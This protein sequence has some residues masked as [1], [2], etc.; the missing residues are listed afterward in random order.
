MENFGPVLDDKLQ[1]KVDKRM[2]IFLVRHFR[3]DFAVGKNE[4]RIQKY[5]FDQLID[6]NF[7]NSSNL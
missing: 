1:S 3:L 5:K 6:L 7:M 4:I 2:Q